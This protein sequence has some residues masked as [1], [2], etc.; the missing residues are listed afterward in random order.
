MI[1]TLQNKIR[2]LEQENRDL[3]QQVVEFN[4]KKFEYMLHCYCGCI[5]CMQCHN[6]IENN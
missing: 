3:K 1:N 6:K 2:I 4:V 5:H